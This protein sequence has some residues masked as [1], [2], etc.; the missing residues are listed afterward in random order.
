MQTAN[1][2][3]GAP[4]AT[5]LPIYSRL[6]P[7]YNSLMITPFTFVHAADLH[8]GTP[9][10]GL[11]EASPEMAAVL[12][13]ATLSAFDNLVALCIEEDA[14]FLV[15]A[16]DVWDG[17]SRSI[18]ALSR[19]RAGVEK[20]GEYGI[21]VFVAA[22]NHD[23]LGLRGWKAAG[24]LP[25]NLRIFQD[26][27]PEA[28]EVGRGGT[29]LAVVH[30]MSYPKAAVSEDLSSRFRRK[31]PEGYEIAV[32]HATVGSGSGHAPYAPT[33]PETLKAS[34]I[35]YWALGHVHTRKTVSEYSPAI[36]YP[37]NIQALSVRETGARGALSVRVDGSGR[38][39]ASFVALDAVRFAEVRVDLSGETDP[40]AAPCRISSALRGAVA[41]AG[42][43]ALVASV[44]LSGRTPLYGPLRREGEAAEL[45]AQLR[46]EAEEYPVP[47]WVGR[48]TNRLSA[49]FDLQRLASSGTLEGEV[50]KEAARLAGAPDSLAAFFAGGGAPLLAK[51]SLRKLLAE[52]RWDEAA[53]LGEAR[54]LALDLLAGEEP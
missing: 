30:G 36:Q 7:V 44:A 25:G 26:K 24:E 31:N 47:V 8:L 3:N 52:E 54:D 28:F 19:F 48:I 12:R 34:G 20:L 23:P 49:P 16:G 41:D 39:N 22:G 33:T 18:R 37:G 51:A 50:A 42:G 2:R 43:R 32:L 21:D 4:P 45:L 6:P 29:T 27:K 9:F 53:I 17:P 1:V 35:D 14:A 40:S 11:G 15:V 13:D 10:T 38:A 46:E 5:P